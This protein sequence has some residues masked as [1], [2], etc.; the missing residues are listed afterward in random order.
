MKSS[1][2]KDINRCAGGPG[3]LVSSVVPGS[4]AQRAGIR[5]GD[6]LIEINRRPIR[7]VVDYF[8]ESAVSD[9]VLTVL[10]GNSR[11]ELPATMDQDQSLGL[12]FTEEL[13]DGIR[14]C[15]DHCH[16]CFMDQMPRGL[17]HTLYL[18]DDDYRLSFLHGTFITLD[19]LE[20]ADW[21]RIESQHLGPLHV[22]VQTTNPE[23]RRKLMGNPRAGEIMERLARLA[24]MSLEIHAQVVVCPDINDGAELA[25]TLAD[26][27]S[28][29]P[30]V[31]SIAVVPVGL[32]DRRFEIQREPAGAHRGGPQKSPLPDLRPVDSTLAGRILD[33]VGEFRRGLSRRF[34]EPLV[35]GADELY[36]VAGRPIPPWGY[37][38]AFPQLENG[39]G[40]V[41]QIWT[42]F[43]RRRR[44]LPRA[45]STPRKVRVVTGVL[46]APVLEPLAATLRRIEGLTV[47]VAA[48]PNR[49]FGPSVTVSG[50][51][52]GQDI[53]THLKGFPEV[54]EILLSAGCLK[55]GSLFLD[56]LTIE[57]F[58]V[59][60]S[61][62]V[63][64]VWP[65]AS[66]LIDGSL[67]KGGAIAG[68]K[69]R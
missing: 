1:R 60:L 69:R 12:D 67:Q 21:D 34:G 47:E 35:H 39:V 27:G 31:A 3:G 48:V 50:L 58:A 32:T 37:Y 26:L 16:F 38:S 33:L 15:R 57:D 22:S 59:K 43:A 44:Y 64:V 54:D 8:F 63:R 66:G 29:Y 6:R 52:G 42:G 55:D 51:L 2:P 68:A 61:T 30:A 17:R 5:P 25:R 40:L 62:P 10:R 46:A 65:T 36:L 4:A 18:K 28:L 49:L 23:L 56:D 14:R 41:R 45:I 20:E 13:W 24:A 7:D 19:N 53:I 9:P 11:L